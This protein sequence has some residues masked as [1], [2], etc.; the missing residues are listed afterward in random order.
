MAHS[1][2]KCAFTEKTF[3]EIC[4]F[5]TLQPAKCTVWCTISKHRPTGPIFVEGIIKNQQYLQ[6]LENR[7]FQ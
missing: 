3:Y 5:V 1:I 2:E 6:Q 4:S 7:S